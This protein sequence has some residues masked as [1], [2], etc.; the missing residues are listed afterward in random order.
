MIDVMA[1]TKTGRLVVLS[2]PSGVG[3][4]TVVARLIESCPLPLKLSVS[5]TTRPIRGDDQPGK[6]YFFLSDEEFQ[7]R[8]KNDEFLEYT[9][10]FGKGHWYGTLREPV[11][12]ALKNGEWF[13]LEIDVEG[14]EKVKKSYSQA[15]SIFLHPGSLEELERRLRGRDQR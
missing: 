5:A 14:A 11:T 6:N 8:V 10:V 2:G 12:T 7:K 15:L 9:E 4:S 13:I 1:D 3:K